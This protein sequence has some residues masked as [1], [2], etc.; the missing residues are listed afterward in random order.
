MRKQGK[1]LRLRA[2]DQGCLMRFKYERD[3]VA[4]PPLCPFAAQ[5]QNVL[6]LW[7][8]LMS[9][10]GL[11][12]CCKPGVHPTVPGSSDGESQG[13]KHSQAV[14]NIPY[15]GNF[16]G[17]IR[18]AM[19]QTPTSP[20]PHEPPTGVWPPWWRA[21]Q[22]TCLP[23]RWTCCCQL[24]STRCSRSGMGLCSV[25]RSCCLRSSRRVWC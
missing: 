14:V 10:R 25:C 3:A 9:C 4:L 13:T 12:M 5:G 8:H 19:W 16:A 18:H 15:Q 20:A 11:T 22:S 7:Q 21:A 17:N 1:A 2:R 6:A 23:Q 24:A